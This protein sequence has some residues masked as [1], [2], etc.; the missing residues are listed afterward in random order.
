MRS[1]LY[2]SDVQYSPTILG[3]VLAKEP[4]HVMFEDEVRTWA[5]KITANE[6]IVAISGDSSA[7]VL[8]IISTRCAQF[9]LI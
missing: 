5:E 7:A 2:R 3:E 6:V 1:E 4:H 8:A 9:P